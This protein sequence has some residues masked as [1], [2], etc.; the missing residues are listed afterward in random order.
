MIPTAVPESAL[1]RDHLYRESISVFVQPD[2]LCGNP[3]ATLKLE[4]TDGA[5]ICFIKPIW[6]K[7]SL[8][9]VGR[10]IAPCEFLV[11]HLLGFPCEAAF[12]PKFRES[13]VAEGPVVFV[14]LFYVGHGV[15]PIIKLAECFSGRSEV[16][17]GW[18][19]IRKLCSRSSIG[20]ES[21]YHSLNRSVSLS[22]AD[23]RKRLK[24]DPPLGPLL[25]QCWG[26]Y[27][28]NVA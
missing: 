13:L 22:S 11:E 16:P 21:R 5:H 17:S 18:S 24:F 15:D 10:E 12:R 28:S 27:Q 19:A 1:R 2:N 3:L 9:V 8:C 26:R 6:S 14:K 20:D 23:R 7:V 25:P 4:D